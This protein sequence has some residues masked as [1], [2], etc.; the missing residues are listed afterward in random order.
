MDESNA[1]AKP[2][3]KELAAFLRYWFS[4]QGQEPPKTS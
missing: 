2:D 3:P 1:G 4:E